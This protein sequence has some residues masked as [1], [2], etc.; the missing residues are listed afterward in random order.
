MP[1]PETADLHQTAVLW[2]YTGVT[3]AYGQPRV[4]APVEIPARWLTARLER[5]DARTEELTFDAVAVLDRA[6]PVHS[7]MWLGTLAEWY[8]TGSSGPAGAELMEVVRFEETPSLRNVD[9]YR[10]VGLKRW[11]QPDGQA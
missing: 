7:R 8:A 9:F 4:A 5:A 10:E 3:D 2:A 1:A 6:V 11:R